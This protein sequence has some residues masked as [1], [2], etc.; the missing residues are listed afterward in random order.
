M[1]ALDLELCNYGI[2]WHASYLYH[3]AIV[4]YL[5]LCEGY[6]V[7]GNEEYRVIDT[8]KMNIIKKPIG[9]TGCL[10]YSHQHY[11]LH[12]GTIVL[13]HTHIGSLYLFLFLHSTDTYIYKLQQRTSIYYLTRFS[14]ALNI[15]LA[16]GDKHPKQDKA[17]TS[18]CK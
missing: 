16:M 11:F 8:V 17:D 4:N 10:F 12:G 14:T 5:L 6:E 13:S 1:V 7:S 2:P 3:V 15:S 9:T 18:R